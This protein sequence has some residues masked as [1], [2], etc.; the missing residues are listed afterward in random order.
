MH[1][2]H[3]AQSGESGQQG[4]DRQPG[5]DIQRS[6]DRT[7]DE[8]EAATPRQVQRR[9]K[10][11]TTRKPVAACDPNHPGPQRD[12]SQKSKGNAHH[13]QREPQ[14]DMQDEVEEI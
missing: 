14:P 12:E 3:Q 11:A 9:S 8:Q 2:D 6:A 1:P 4:H 7:P 5:N 13:D 10:K